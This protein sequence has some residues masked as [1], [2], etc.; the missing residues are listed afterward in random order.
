M[1]YAMEPDKRIQEL[2]QSSVQTLVFDNNIP[3]KRYFRSGKEILRMASVYKEEGNDEKVFK[4]YMR[5]IR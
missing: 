3:I 4:L 2:V 1:A 5:Y